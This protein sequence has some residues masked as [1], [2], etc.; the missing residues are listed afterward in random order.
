MTWLVVAL[1]A[2][3]LIAIGAYVMEKQRSAALRRRFG[4]E[5][6]RALGDADGNR[7]AAETQLRERLRRRAAVDVRD[8]E[9]AVRAR[10]SSRW[11]ALQMGFVDD[12]AAAVAEAEALVDQLVDDRGYAAAASADDGSDEDRSDEDRY[13]LVAV[14]HAVAVEQHRQARGIPDDGPVDDLRQAFLHHRALFEALLG[15][16]SEDGDRRRGAGRAVVTESAVVRP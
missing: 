5:Y 3:A 10:Y 7:R 6:E 4:P 15:D 13:E 1:V 16:A 9:P 14:D 2:V 8:L 12:P 11:R